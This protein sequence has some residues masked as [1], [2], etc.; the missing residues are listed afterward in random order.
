MTNEEMAIRFGILGS[1]HIA[2]KLCKAIITAPNATLQA[3]GSRSLEKAT[4]FAAEHGLPATVRVYGSYQAVLDDEEVDA[5]YIP[6]PTSLHVTW[7]VM[8]AEK[9]KHVLLEKPVA[10]NVAELD[11]IIE[12]C[13]GHGVQF[14]DGTMWVHHPRTAK[15]KE[16]L[17]DA[18][19]FGQLKWVS[20]HLFLFIRSIVVVPLFCSFFL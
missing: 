11:R 14:M 8:A 13:E 7:A 12:A 5:I 9:G 17:S 1:A 15:M 3:I 6:L 4:A 18:H 10:M 2:I 20:I 16:A 19:R